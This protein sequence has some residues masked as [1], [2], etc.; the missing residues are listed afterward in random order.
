MQPTHIGPHETAL[1]L[2]SGGAEIADGLWAANQ[3]PAL[4][5]ARRAALHHGSAANALRYFDEIGSRSNWRADDRDYRCALRRL[6]AFEDG[7]AG[8]DADEYIAV[9]KGD[10]LISWRARKEI[11]ER[12]AADWR[13]ELAAAHAGLIA[14]AA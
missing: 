6:M 7:S 10:A 9:A 12:M 5:D 8:S 1:R 2:I 3:T 14:R 11:V 4:V 13:H